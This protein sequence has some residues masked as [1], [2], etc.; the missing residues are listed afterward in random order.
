MPWRRS[1]PGERPRPA[2]SRPLLPAAIRPV[3]AVLLAVCVTVTVF[4]GTRVWHQTLPG[5]PDTAVDMRVRVIF[6]GYRAILNYLV[7]LGDPRTV[8]GLTAALLVACLAT[9]RWRGAVLV[10]VS[11]PAASVL[12]EDLLK[13]FIDRSYQGALDFP[14]GHSTAVFTLATASAVLLAGPLR[15]RIGPAPRL[16][17]ALAA[18]GV[19][20][21]VAIALVGLGYHYFTDTVAG[22][23]VGIAVVLA[24]TLLL[25]GLAARSKAR[26]RASQSSAEN[27][28]I[29][30]RA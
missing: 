8:A 10:A 5:W 9:R 3:A 2:I 29:R 20:V 14:S 21:S 26:E 12:T 24:V 7:V 23:T 1:N 25:D 11:V 18:F 28:L 4:L 16:L 19:A 13:P 27:R 15:V 6:G 17:L 30:P 22:A